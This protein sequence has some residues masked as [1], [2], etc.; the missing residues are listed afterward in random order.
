MV[1]AKF[2]E[3]YAI[4]YEWDLWGRLRSLTLSD[5]YQ[6]RYRYDPR[7]R[8]VSVEDNQTGQTSYT[9]QDVVVIR[10][11][12]NGVTSTFRFTPDGLLHS[13]EHR[14][15][16]GALIVAYTYMYDPAGKRTAVEE[17][18]PSGTQ[19]T[20][21]EYDALL[22]LKAV[23]LPD[24]TTRTYTYD[25][26][27]NR[28][29][30]Q[31]PEGTTPY[32]YDSFNR[33]S[34]AGE[35]A[36]FWDATGNLA[37]RQRESRQARYR[38]DAENRLLELRTGGGTIQYTYSGEGLLLKRQS[39]SMSTSYLHHIVD[40][41]PQI[42]AEYE[43]QSKTATHYLLGPTRLARISQEGVVYYLE[44]GL[45]SVRH[46]IDDTGTVTARYQYSAFGLPQKVEG[47]GGSPFL[48]NGELWDADAGLLYLRARWYDP[49][50]GR[51]ISRDPFLGSVEDPQTFNAYAYARNDPVN[52]VDP[53]GLQSGPPPVHY[54]DPQRSKQSSPP[55]QAVLPSP[56]GSTGKCHI[57]ILVCHSKGCV[58]LRNDARTLGNLLEKGSL[59]IGKVYYFGAGS[60]GLL[61]DVLDKHGIPFVPYAHPQDP[62]GWLTTHPADLLPEI[63]TAPFWRRPLD[64]LGA[65]LG[66]ESFKVFDVLGGLSPD[67]GL[68]RNLPYH[69]LDTYYRDYFLKHE[70]ALPPD[71]TY[72]LITGVGS[73][74]REAQEGARRFFGVGSAIGIR[75]ATGFFPLDAIT[76]TWDQEWGTSSQVVN[77]MMGRLLP[78]AAKPEE[79]L[80]LLMRAGDDEQKKYF[81]PFPPGG[82]GGAAG[83]GGV[84]LDQAAQVLG[85]LGSIAGVVYDEKRNRLILV[86]EN[87]ESAAQ[88]ALPP[89]RLDDVAVALRA[90]FSLNPQ[91]S[92]VSID[93]SP[94]ALQTSTDGQSTCGQL[95]PLDLAADQSLPAIPGPP[96]VVSFFGE[97]TPRSHLGAILFEADRTM[98]NL[99]I[100][101]DNLT[102]QDMHLPVE[103][104]YSLLDLNLSNLPKPT[105]K[106]WNRFWLV[107][108]EN[109]VVLRVA[110]DG[111]SMFVERATVAVKTET[112]VQRNGKLVPAEGITDARAEYFAHWL[113]ANYDEVARYYPVFA[114]LRQVAV[115]VGVARWIHKMGLPVDPWW[116]HNS[117]PVDTP[118]TTPAFI[119]GK[120][121]SAAELACIYGGVDLD[122]KPFLA[123]DDGKAQ[124]L[125]ETTL[126]TSAS[127]EDA[128]AWQV[129]HQGKTL[130]AVVLP[131]PG[132]PD[133]GSY[134]SSHTDLV[135]SPEDSVFPLTRHY[136]S[137]ANRSS[138]FGYGWSFDL[139]RLYMQ[140]RLVREKEGE[141]TKEKLTPLRATV[142]DDFGGLRVL[143]DLTQPVADAN[144]GEV[145]FVPE[146]AGM[147]RSL[148]L[149]K[150]WSTS[151][152][153]QDGQQWRF[154]QKGLLTEQQTPAGQVRYDWDESDQLVQIT[155]ITHSGRQTWARLTYD[156]AG[157][158]TSMTD[159]HGRQVTYSY[160]PA[161]DL[162]AMRSQDGTVQQSYAYD[163]D[164]RLVQVKDQE[165]LLWEGGYD[166]QGYLIWQRD[167]NSD[168]V[169]FAHAGTPGERIIT[170]KH[171]DTL[172][173]RVYNEKLQLAR[174]EGDQTKVQYTYLPDGQ[175]QAI[176]ATDPSGAKLRWEISTD[177]RRVTKTDARGVTTEYLFDEKARPTQIAI[178]GRPLV[179]Y[180]YAATGRQIEAMAEGERMR[181]AFDSEGRLLSYTVEAP[182]QE[183]GARLTVNY[184]YGTDGKLQEVRDSEGG[185]QRFDGKDQAPDF[186]RGQATYTY[187]PEGRLTQ[188]KDAAGAVTTYTLTTAGDL[189]Q[190]TLPD[191]SGLKVSY[192]QGGRPVRIVP[193]PRQS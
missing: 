167:G 185:S 23:H 83:V 18:S 55:L 165:R 100:S 108:P 27:G 174:I 166:A 98:K 95:L 130:N 103:G 92:A 176:E 43:E 146:Q 158:V 123:Q 125:K 169:E 156:P 84:L 63:G 81:P 184:V 68:V 182:E 147:V 97:G 175:V 80:P 8:L 145:S 154:N 181:A 12:P 24:G 105:Q 20:R 183:G 134:T 3:G 15:A 22:R 40:G 38:Y 190:A 25:A 122:V 34:V 160:D 69:G 90:L 49:S 189:Q 71:G 149:Q 177:Q 4:A 7:G 91:P 82:G 28:L 89:V 79:R 128:P 193:L 131:G 2:P 35:T 13:L 5:G 118:T 67:I 88:V 179:S 93:P 121:L 151:I 33:L 64:R 164:H 191:G 114:E 76:A 188:V 117:P 96:M 85:D 86:G 102:A 9:Y 186:D 72:I 168:K 153:L 44:D 120:K 29:V 148:S 180:R 30:E 60:P 112:M 70:P 53:S 62:V 54:P 73:G 51:F 163:P 111:T 155:A 135:L 50:I 14:Q 52:R 159:T 143:F 32:K 66:T 106:V 37:S 57:D 94:A 192:D 144:S 187:A 157:R 45:G 139:P 16:T 119:V 113:T 46:L 136:S 178:G 56:C 162:V 75:S 137:F 11:L 170:V 133:V 124:T 6:I 39:G 78:R 115:A 104:Y 140:Y 31:T 161:G 36:Y 127:A 129:S 59:S 172:L 19:T 1:E 77:R 132:V 152:F 58:N 26:L 61:K 10:R 173:K 138:A 65:W 126:R 17:R 21:Y 142:L 48:F 141:K 150:D 110:P 74:E 47:T 101:K 99:S 107:V 109:C 41:L 87:R 171:G 42:V 116:V